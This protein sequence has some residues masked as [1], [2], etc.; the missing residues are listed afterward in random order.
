[1]EASGRRLE[2]SLGLSEVSL[3]VSLEPPGESRPYERTSDDSLRL[4]IGSVNMF[5]I[6]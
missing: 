1:M 4:S 3:H 5:I 2:A 6:P